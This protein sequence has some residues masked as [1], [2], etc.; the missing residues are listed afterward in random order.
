MD[1]R[2]LSPPRVNIGGTP[3]VP[4]SGGWV[5]GRVGLPGGFREGRSMSPLAPSGPVS[6]ERRYLA[7]KKKDGVEKEEE[8]TPE[9]TPVLTKRQTTKLANTWKNGE[10]GAWMNSTVSSAG[11]CA[12][13]EVSGTGA[14]G[15]LYD[16]L[17]NDEAIKDLGVEETAEE[18]WKKADEL[19]I[20]LHDME[21]IIEKLKQ[22]L[23]RCEKHARQ[24][25]MDTELQDDWRVRKHWGV[26]TDHGRTFD[27]VIEDAEDTVVEA[28]KRLHTRTDRALD[29]LCETSQEISRLETLNRDK[30]LRIAE[31]EAENN[32][33]H[34]QLSQ[35][36]VL[37]LEF[38]K[39]QASV[40]A[41]KDQRA[42]L[43]KELELARGQIAK[44]TFDHDQL[45]IEVGRLVKRNRAANAR[46]KEEMLP[47]FREEAKGLDIKGP[48]WIPTGAPY[49]HT[50]DD[51][52]VLIKKHNP[53]PVS[54]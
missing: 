49:R 8:T 33:L 13:L 23:L 34:Q 44:L 14:T 27:E 11:I 12:L 54:G 4:A 19:E 47:L 16:I 6:G 25:T 20:E 22:G 7:R 38:Q 46:S 28:I 9:P 50:L 21:G 29:E 43:S 15:P 48:A 17:V 30:S 36:T 24:Y 5:R 45:R 51:E 53:W 39:K 42:A 18:A 40:D 41:L 31:L 2:S 37:L 32:K 1:H 52:A 35:Q 26:L 3:K 10:D